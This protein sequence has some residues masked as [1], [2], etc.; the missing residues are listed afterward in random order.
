MKHFHTEVEENCSKEAFQ[1]IIERF[2]K[3]KKV[4]YTIIP[5]YYKDFLLDIS[6]NFVEIKKIV[7]DKYSFPKSEGILGYINDDELQFVFEFYERANVIPFVIASRNV[8][9]EEDIELGSFYSYFEENN[10][11]HITVG[12]DQEY[13]TYYSD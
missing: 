10:I 2:L 4:I 12:H 1:K 8:T 7:D 5:E 9:F 3:K 13:I 6:S 11:P